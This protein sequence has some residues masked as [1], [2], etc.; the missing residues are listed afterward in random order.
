MRC[1]VATPAARTCVGATAAGSRRSR[2]MRYCEVRLAAV[3]SAVPRARRILQ[4]LLR[5]WRLESI[6]DPALLLASELLTNAVQASGDSCRGGRNQQVIV[7]TVALT[8]TSVLLQVWDPSPALPVLRETDITSD[9]GRGLVLVDFLADAW[10]YRPADGGKV[11][12]CELA[13]P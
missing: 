10:G 1:E 6:S 5:E 8:E 3:P 9:R 12:W 7:L 2:V 11:V 13:R 4:R